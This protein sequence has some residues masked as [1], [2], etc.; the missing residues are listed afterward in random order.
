MGYETLRIQDRTVRWHY[1]S[2]GPL[3]AGGDFKENLLPLKFFCNFFQDLI[4]K[5]SISLSST[6]HLSLPEGAGI[7]KVL[8]GFLDSR[9]DL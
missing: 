5:G 9:K 3:P 2:G 4:Q 8:S 6:C 7:I 1:I